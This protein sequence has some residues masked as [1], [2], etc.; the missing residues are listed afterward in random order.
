[1]T[2]AARG[3]GTFITFEGIDGSGKSTQV[4]RLAD[5][6]LANGHEVVLTREPGGS[7]GAEEI[8]ALVL[9]GD[10]D[11]WSAETEILLFTAARR[12][13]L[14]RTILPALA[15]GKIVICDRFADS[16][17][18]YQGLSRGDLR[19][20]V[21]QLHTLMIGHEPDLTILIDMD[22]GVGLSR[23]LSR[24]TVDERFEAFGEDLQ[25]AMRQGFLDL[26]RE[27]SDRFR[28]IDGARDMDAVAGDIADLVSAE[29]A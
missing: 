17:R 23:A 14:E 19:G 6:L 7:P 5:H 4:K 26:A 20:V 13:H 28:V 27:F 15:A 8:R 9:Q 1:M 3:T 16:T 11:R 29:L 21:D 18:M 22:P 25:K 24:Q 12:D 2:A 10:P